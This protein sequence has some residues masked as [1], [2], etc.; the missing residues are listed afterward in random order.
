MKIGTTDI[1]DMFLGTI[2]VKKIFSG[3]TLLYEKLLTPLIELFY[4]GLQINTVVKA[5][6]DN[7]STLNT[8]ISYG[9][10]IYSIA[11]DDMHIYVGGYTTNAVENIKDLKSDLSYVGETPSY[12]GTIYSIE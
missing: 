2:E 1:K 6:S 4:G 10:T 3:T 12:G 9:G 11:V 8:S 7:L 5:N